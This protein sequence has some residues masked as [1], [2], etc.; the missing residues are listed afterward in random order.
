MVKNQEFLGAFSRIGC[1]NVVDPEV[2]TL[3]EKFVCSMY[4]QAKCQDVNAARFA[5]FTNMYAPKNNEQ[6]LQKIKSSD[7]CCLPPCKSVLLQKIKRCNYITH[8]YKNSSVAN[9]IDFGPE[10][11]GWVKD[12]NGQLEILWYDGPR[13]PLKHEPKTLDDSDDD[14]DLIYAS[15]SDSEV[16]DEDDD[17]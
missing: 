2:Y 4:G 8:L 7:P 6:P 10:G 16:D 15:S 12:D 11:Y 9:P 3:I 1:S 5:I 13:C 17:E 14:D